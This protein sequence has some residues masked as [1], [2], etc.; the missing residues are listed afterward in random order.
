MPAHRFVNQ[1]ERIAAILDSLIKCFNRGA[2]PPHE[3]PHR[4][5]TILVATLAP[6]PRAREHAA[7]KSVKHLDRG[8]GKSGRKVDHC[9]RQRRPP[10]IDAVI[11]KQECR[12]H[13]ALADKLGKAEFRNGAP[14]YRVATTSDERSVGQECVS[15][16]RSRWSPCN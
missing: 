10:A 13:A 12:C 11:R 3:V 6:T 4:L 1:F 16:C 7:D 8:I 14:N 2:E 15:T 9:G 5:N